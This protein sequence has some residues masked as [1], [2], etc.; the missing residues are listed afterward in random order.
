VL[1]AINWNML[2]KMYADAYSQNITDGQKVIVCKLLHNPLNM[3]S[4]AYP[5][6]ELHL[7]KWFQ[8]LP[9]DHAEMEKTIINNKIDNLIGILNWDLSE[10]EQ[11]IV[12][13]NLFTF[14]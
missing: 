12:L 11:N 6:D 14:N 13:N 1:A 4:V 3:T 2:K 10:T 8:E 5:I 9:F 7:P